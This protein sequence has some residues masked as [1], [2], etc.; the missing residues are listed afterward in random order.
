VLRLEIG[1]AGKGPAVPPEATVWRDYDGRVGAFGFTVDG[2]HWMRL[3][4]VGSFR[5]SDGGEQVTSF[6]ER[7]VPADAVRDAYRRTVLPMALQA[8]GWEVLHASAVRMR[9]GVVALCAVSR[10]GKSTVAYALSRRGHRLFADDAVPYDLTGATPRAIPLPFELHLR[11]E[12]ASFFDM[13]ESAPSEK[14]DGEVVP[15]AALCVLER[16]D[17]ATLGGPVRVR[18]LSPT[19]SFPR[20]LAHAYCFDLESAERRGRMVERYL[21]LVS[22]VPVF[23]VHLWPGLHNLGHVVDAIERAVSRPAA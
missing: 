6:A 8:L 18:P 7:G 1:T 14:D 23:E 17:P 12:S 13:S 22:R 15:L 20:V 16:A 19:A 3:P 11:A 5:F 9:R 4:G 21:E 2:D 10:T